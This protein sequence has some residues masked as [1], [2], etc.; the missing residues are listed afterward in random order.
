MIDFLKESQEIFP[1]IREYRRRF[2]ERPELSFRERETT[3]AIEEILNGLNVPFKKPL[4]TGLIGS[5]GKGGK[6]IALRADIDALPIKEETGLPFASKNEGV[7]HACGHDIHAACLLG[8]ATILKKHERELKGEVALIFQPA[9]EKLPGGAKAIV[10]SGA[11]ENPEPELVLGQHIYPEA[12]TGTISLASGYVMA[13]PDELY[14][15]IT[16]KGGHAA[17]PHKNVDCVLASAAII[18]YLH[19]TISKFKDPTKAGLISITSINAG[20]APNVFPDEAKMSG[21]LR[22]FDEDWRKLAHKIIL[23]ASAKIAS[24][25]GAKCEVEI[26]KG[27]PALKNDSRAAEFIKSVAEELF[28]TEAVKNFEPKMWGED[29][30]YYARKYP[31][32][33]WFLGVGG[34]DPT[35]TPP[36]HS[37][38]L[39]PD[40]NAIIYGTAL[41]AAAAFKYLSD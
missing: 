38:K 4:E 17:Q 7:S 13:A 41:L 25:Y 12:K 35:Q 2:H 36:L 33:F 24:L 39:I 28:G 21:T 40:E 31:S 16:G 10:E 34:D 6:K 5:V 19:T 32:V 1:K 29:F 20:S 23:E 18:Q 22:S 8:A 3:A 14:W 37:S 11:L 26:K 9:E 15:T 30:A 27:Y